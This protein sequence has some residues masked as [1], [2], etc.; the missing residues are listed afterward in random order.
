MAW[1]RIMNAQIARGG[2]NEQSPQVAP[3]RWCSI[4]CN[5]RCCGGCPIP[6]AAYPPDRG[7]RAAAIRISTRVISPTNS[8]SN[9]ASRSWL[10]T[11]PAPAA[12]SATRRWRAR[13][14]TVIRWAISPTSSQRI[15]ACTRL[16]Y[17]FARDFQPLLL[18]LTGLNVLT[19]APALPVR[20]VKE[21]IEYARANPGKLSY[22]TSGSGRVP[23]CRWNYSK[24]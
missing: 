9:W 18:Y 12:L 15:P 5:N 14:R 24:P 23:I 20:S 6:D 21:L 10:K 8:A 2:G 22:G 16:P 7:L 17:D 13:H 3:Y 1:G 4:D 19:V 11:A